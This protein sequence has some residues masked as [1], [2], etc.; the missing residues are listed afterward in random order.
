MVA[1]SFSLAVIL[2]FPVWLFAPSLMWPASQQSESMSGIPAAESSLPDGGRTSSPSGIIA[3]IKKL[4]PTPLLPTGLLPITPSVSPSNPTKHTIAATSTLPWRAYVDPIYGH[5]QLLPL[6]CEAAAAADW[7]AF[8]HTP[9]LELAFF[10][11]IPKAENPDYGFVGDVNDSWGKLPPDGYGVYA[12]PIAIVLRSLGLPAYAYRGLTFDQVRGEIAA[13]RPVMVWVIGHI[14]LSRAVTMELGGKHALVAPY[15]HTVLVIGY[16]YQKVKV[17]DGIDRV[18]VSEVDF[19][20]SWK[21]LGNMTVM[22]R[23]AGDGA[24]DLAA[25]VELK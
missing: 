25:L 11:L 12:G 2:F 5:K 6:D 1:L 10:N 20:N 23:P 15:E 14:G 8:F 21:I 19:L 7:A 3:G 4:S 13:G 9:V 17:L 22:A 18:T 16:E 24:E